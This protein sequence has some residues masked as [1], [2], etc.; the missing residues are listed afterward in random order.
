Q[1]VDPELLAGRG[2]ERR[3]RTARAAGRVEHAVDDERRAL[4]AVLGRRAEIGRAEPPREL[5]RAEVARVDL[6]ERRVTGVPEIAAVGRPFAVGRSLPEARA[7]ED[8]A[9][10]RRRSSRRNR[11]QR[12]SCHRY[13]A[14]GE[15]LQ[16]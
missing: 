1:A 11:A 16:Y 6:V 10:E 12:V 15:P 13:S 3:D 9:R 4:E 5:E 7:R 14:A 2:V 8:E